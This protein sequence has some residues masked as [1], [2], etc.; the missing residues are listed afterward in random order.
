M[1]EPPRRVAVTGAS[2]YIARRLIERLVGLEGVERVLAT[3]IRPSSGPQV[4]KVEFLRQDVGDP[5]PD[6]FVGRELD[7]VVH[8]AYILNPRHNR[9]TARRV[10]V[11]GTVN[12]LEACARGDVGHILYLS[13]TSV[14]GAHP[15]NADFMSEDTPVRPLEG[16][17]YSE[18]KAEAEGLLEQFAVRNP[19]VAVTVL[20][21]CPVLGPHTDNFI[22]R[23][24]T[25][26]ILVGA[27]GYDP[28]MQFL[29]EDDLVEI[30]MGCMADRQAG[31]YNLAGDGTVRW[32]EGAE[33]LGRRVLKLPPS[34]LYALTALGWHL[35]L[36]SESPACGINFIRYRWTADTGKAQRELGATFRY[37]S[38]QALEAFT[39]GAG[40]AVSSQGH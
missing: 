14:Y 5:F 37:T 9:R 8:L 6:L 15:D 31:T 22:S 38:R 13:S 7:A 16:Y 26:S 39:R 23:A 21:A 12:L 24:L 30:M 17:Q 10:N 28:P 20:R 19:G 1:S 36:Q 35:R 2:G 27:N 3:D 33:L 29:H 34:V 11:Q 32:S 4:P 40:S 25:R 18:D